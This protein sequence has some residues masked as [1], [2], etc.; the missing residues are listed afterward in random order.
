MDHFSGSTTSPKQEEFE[1]H[2]YSAHTCSICRICDL[3]EHCYKFLS[4][5]FH[6]IVYCLQVISK[7]QKHCMCT[8]LPSHVT[9]F[10]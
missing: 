8:I 5:H 6:V 10:Y 9:E 4:S 7:K 3:Y 1:T 2:K